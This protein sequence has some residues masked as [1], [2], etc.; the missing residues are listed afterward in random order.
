[1]RLDE[2]K[3]VSAAEQRVRRM[4]RRP[5]TTKG[6]QTLVDAALEDLSS[7]QAQGGEDGCA[8]ELTGPICCS[9]RTCMRFQRTPSNSAS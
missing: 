1:M 4:R 9:A 8:G 2:I 7:V 5:R 6:F 3:A